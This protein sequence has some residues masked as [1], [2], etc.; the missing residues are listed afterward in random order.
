MI[1]TY[2]SLTIA[3]DGTWT[4]TLNNADADTNALAQG[5]I[6]DRRVQPTR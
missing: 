5:Q 4:Y 3:A 2:G 6:V 1:G